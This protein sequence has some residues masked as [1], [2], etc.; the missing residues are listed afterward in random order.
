MAQIIFPGSGVGSTQRTGNTASANY[1]TVAGGVSNQTRGIY[2]TIGGGITS[3]I[4]SSGSTIGGGQSNTIGQTGTLP[5]GQQRLQSPNSTILGGFSNR[6]INGCC[7]FIGGGCGNYVDGFS[8][9]I[10]GGQKNTTYDKVCESTI[11]GGF[12]NTTTNSWTTIGGGRFNT[13]R[14]IYSTVVGGSGNTTNSCFNTIIGGRNQKG[15]GT[16]N[17]VGGGCQNQ[18]NG[19]FTTIGG[20]FLNSAISENSTIGGGNSNTISNNSQRSVIIGGSCNKNINSELSFLGGGLGNTTNNL[21]TVI[22]GGRSNTA[23]GQ[24]SSILGGRLNTASGSYSTVVGGAFNTAVGD[25]SFVISTNSKVTGDRSVV[26][27]GQNLVGSSDDTVY[28]PFLN[29]RDLGPSLAVTNIGVDAN[30]NVVPGQNSS[31]TFAVDGLLVEG[32]PSPLGS[33]FPDPLNLSITS[34]LNGTTQSATSALYDDFGTF[35]PLTGSWT[36]PATGRYN[37]SFF[38]HLT[39]SV[40]GWQ[41]PSL[42]P[43]TN[44]D[45]A[46]IAGLVNP[47]TN[48]VYAANNF[49]PSVPQL[50]ADINGAQWGVELSAGDQVCLRIMNTSGVFYTPSVGDYFRFSLQKI[51]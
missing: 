37:L 16:Y 35:N 20:G 40:N 9:T 44:L 31:G 43:G 29:I 8:N 32:S 24:A 25:N 34:L 10:I 50:Y 33:S 48:I 46:I 12:S 41:N 28:V 2:G 49:F 36:C 42:I 13:A 14:G 22:G 11:G 4:M 23:T 17:F 38:I 6:T 18:T 15:I 26:V 19:N 39:D 21:N 1:S 7:N 5:V 3:T 51:G 30:G 47:V 27:G 45:S